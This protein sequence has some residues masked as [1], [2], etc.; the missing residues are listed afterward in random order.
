[1]ILLAS[2]LIWTLANGLYGLALILI[3]LVLLHAW[4]LPAL[5][6]KILERLLDAYILWLNGP[7]RS[8]P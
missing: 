1:M 3:G 2:L 7:A 4:F 6:A 5:L 8:D